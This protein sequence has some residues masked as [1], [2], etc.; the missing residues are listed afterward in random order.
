MPPLCQPARDVPVISFSHRLSWNSARWHSV[1]KKY[2]FH[3]LKRF[4]ILGS[5]ET[6]TECI[7]S[8]LAAYRFEYILKKDR[9]LKEE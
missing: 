7:L 8:V 4:A 6:R 3:L 1:F 5:G 9:K 2:L